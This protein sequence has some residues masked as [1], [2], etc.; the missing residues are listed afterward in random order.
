MARAVARFAGV[1]TA[2]VGAAP[3]Q[4]LG[5]LAGTA[6]GG[7]AAVGVGV[8]WR[9]RLGSRATRVHLT[10]VALAV[11]LVVPLLAL[12]NLLGVPG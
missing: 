10:A 11:R 8:L 12:W 9:R 7:L 4:Y 6:L 5:W 2:L 1:I 3:L